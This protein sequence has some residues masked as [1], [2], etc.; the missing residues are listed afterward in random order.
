MPTDTNAAAN[1]VTENAANGTPVGLTASANDADATDN[2]VTYAISA[3]LAVTLHHRRQYRRG[4]GAAGDRPRGD[5]SERD[6]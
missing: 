6:H 5:R 2:T 1:A 4:D 3:V